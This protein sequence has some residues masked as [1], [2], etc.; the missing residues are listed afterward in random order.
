MCFGG[1]S[2]N[3]ST[4]TQTIPPVLQQYAEEN[5]NAARG[6]AARPYETYQGPRVAASDPLQNQAYN[7]A[8]QST[9]QWQ[10]YAQK[11]ADA[12]GALSDPAAMRRYMNPYIQGAL[13]P[14]LDQLKRTFDANR[15]GINAQAH[16]AGA[17]G[18]SGYGIQQGMN[19]RNYGQQVA[20]TT[21][22]AY[23]QAFGNAQQTAQN[24]GQAFGQLAQ[25]IPALGDADMQRLY[26]M[27]EQRR[28]QTQQ[29][30]DTAYQDFQNQFN[31]PINAL[32]V[33]TSVLAGTPYDRTSTTT[34][35]GG[36]S[37]AQNLG[38]FA[39]LAGLGL[40]GYDSFFK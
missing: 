20:D 37:S 17:F 24:Q 38:A 39:T 21:A 34:A 14:T 27:G 8:G 32:N 40:K 13:Q 2:S 16:Q 28:Q 30:Y 22:Q 25:M 11:S 6:V 1:S 9:G 23:T 7:M 19:E 33:R 15:L 3:T 29:S 31:Y 18:D 35:P 26:Q 5:L 36:S 10:P 12:F 4:T